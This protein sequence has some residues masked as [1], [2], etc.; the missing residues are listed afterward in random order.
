MNSEFIEALKKIEEI[1]SIIDKIGDSK[2]IMDVIERIQIISEHIE[3]FGGIAQIITF[4]KEMEQSIYACKTMF[5]L[6]E[7]AKYIGV[8][9]STLYKMTSC[10]QITYYKPTGKCIFIERAELDELMRTN[11][12]YSRKSIERMAQDNTFGLTY[13]NATSRK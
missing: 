11:P 2:S 9:T 13:K 5:T 8:A 6:D 12:I 1:S 7:A 3:K 10:R 4:A